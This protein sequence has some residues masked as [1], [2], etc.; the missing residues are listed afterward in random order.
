MSY[1]VI[2]CVMYGYAQWL[3]DAHGYSSA[4]AGLLMLPMSVA[5]MATSLLGARTQ[6]IRAPLTSPP[7]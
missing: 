5:A 4:A 6:G 3:E 2:Y 7:R 1:L